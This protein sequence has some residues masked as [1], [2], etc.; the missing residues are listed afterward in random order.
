MIF[1]YVRDYRTNEN[2]C[3]ESLGDVAKALNVG[4]SV[5]NRAIADHKAIDRNYIT[6]FEEND[7]YSIL[8]IKLYEEH[9]RQIKD[10][11]NKFKSQ[12]N[13]KTN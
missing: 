4:I 8:L 13:E 6:I 11:T 5:V 10:I 3:Y 1:Y 2:H 7:P 9:K 12:C